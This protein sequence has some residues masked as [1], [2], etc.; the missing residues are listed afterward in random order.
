MRRSPYPLLRIPSKA[1]IPLFLIREELKIRQLFNLFDE[2]G[3]S[4]CAYRPNLDSL[5]LKL[6][7]LD[8]GKDETFA[9]YDAIMERRC[10]KFQGDQKKLIQQTMKT[11]YELVELQKKLTRK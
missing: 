9:L 6:V 1:E 8:D 4:D 3:V 7:D 5:I 2:I 10:R 11:Y